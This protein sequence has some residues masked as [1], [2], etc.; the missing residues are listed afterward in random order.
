MET[1]AGAVPVAGVAVSHV[2]PVLVVAATVKGVFV[3]DEVT[4][5]VCAAGARGRGDGNGLRGRSGSAGGLR[6]RESRRRGTDRARRYGQR[7]WDGK[8]RVRSAGRGHRDLARVTAGG[9]LGAIHAYGD[10]AG[11]LA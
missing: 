6:E 7:D 9:Q 2:P 11:S 4:C 5:T 8:R 3:P 1:A 10:G